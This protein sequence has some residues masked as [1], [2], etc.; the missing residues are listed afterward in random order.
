MIVAKKGSSK[1]V[2]MSKKEQIIR[3]AISGYPH[4]DLV[5]IDFDKLSFKELV[6]KAYHREFGDT[7]L[8]FIVIEL[9][10]GLEG[11]PTRDAAQDL[12]ERAKNDIEYCKEAIRD[13]A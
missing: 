8:S 13:M 7:L 3:R 6:E 4:L 10:E 2:T 11:V 9:N 12:L 5:G 1:K